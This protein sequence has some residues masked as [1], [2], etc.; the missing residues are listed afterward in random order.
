MAR[1]RLISRSVSPSP[2]QTDPT[3]VRLHLERI[4]GSP[5]FLSATRLQ[6]F[7]TF[8]VEQKLEGAVSVKETEVAMQVFHR[9][10]SFDP[11][12]DSVVRVAASN[13]RS[14]LRDYYQSTGAHDNIRIEL[15]KGKYLPTFSVG[16]TPAPQGHNARLI[17][18]TT[19][20][21][22]L[23]FIAAAWWGYSA[24]RD[25]RPSSIAVLPFLNLS[26]NPENE[27]LTDGFVEEVTTSLA[28]VEG[29][30]V[31]AR[32]SSF[33][34][35]GKSPE[36]RVAGRQLGVETILEGSIRTVGRRVRISAQ[37]IKV[38]D[39]F[40]IWS[41]TWDSDGGNLIGVGDELVRLVAGTLQRPSTPR[42]QLPRDPEAYDLYLKGQYVK[43]RITPAELARSVELLRRSIAKDPNYAPAHAALGE[44]LASQA[45]YSLTPDWAL[46]ARAKEEAGK[47]LA[48][49]NQLAHA[50]A[51]LAWIQFFADWD[52]VGSEQGLRRSIQLNPNLARAHDWYAQYLT[53]AGR[54][55]DSLTEARRA[56]SLDPLNYR[57][58]T[59]LSVALY[60]ARHFDE[61]IRQARE[62]MELN[63]HFHLAHTVAGA[64]LQEKGAYREAIVELE[65]AL[66]DNPADADT[67]AHLTAV[68][69]ATGDRA[70]ARKGLDTLEHWPSPAPTPWYE[71]AYAYSVL[72]DRT[73]AF[74]ALDHARNERSSDMPFL[75][76]DPAFE[77]L[78][79]E[80]RFRA[81]EARM[82]WRR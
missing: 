47:A 65:A 62:A 38:S 44:V 69:W 1:I 71:L 78:R 61:A 17:I 59:N 23:L 68:R 53:A 70:A 74:E 49:D 41:H 37:L 34:F 76:A 31:V 63:P 73:R 75:R 55:D 15:P 57:T 81:L 58:S 4:L 35:K 82:G 28:Q 60:C 27:Y 50:H 29:L 18:T 30:K 22:A 3:A 32:S 64:S 39:G 20:G 26:N 14:R 67:V 25:Q 56:L 77:N 72:G 48:L 54:A 11:S 66:R 43:D 9:Q 52:W 46:I 19:A 40:H 24:S 2:K 51:L 16:P 7:L 42:G 12:G 13:L 80:P 45:Y 21:L 79:N 36:V 5:E 33:Q 6:Q 10:S 8:V